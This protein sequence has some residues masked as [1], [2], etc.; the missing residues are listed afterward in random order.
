MSR[1]KLFVAAVTLGTSCTYQGS[2]VPVT[3]DTRMLEGEWEGT[4]SSERSGRTG[5]IL[6]HFKAGTD[7]SVRRRPDDPETGRGDAASDPAPNAQAT[8]QDGSRASDLL[9]SVRG[10]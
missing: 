7:F 10:R 9:H 4:Y 6:F 5:S 8:P 3:G 1:M 2:P